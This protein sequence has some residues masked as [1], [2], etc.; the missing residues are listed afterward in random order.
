M[1]FLLLWLN[2]YQIPYLIKV[3]CPSFNPDKAKKDAIGIAARVSDLLVEI[4]NGGVQ[5]CFIN[6]KRI[7]LEIRALA[8]TIFRYTKQIDQWLSAS[9]SINSA[10]KV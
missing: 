3:T 8:S 2:S 5:E 6:E 7:E 1:S 10:I 9:H 4:V